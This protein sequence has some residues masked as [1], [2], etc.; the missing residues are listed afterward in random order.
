MSFQFFRRRKSPAL[1]PIEIGRKLLRALDDAVDNDTEGRLLGPDKFTIMLSEFDREA[2]ANDERAL[3]DELS[4]AATA[5]IRDEGLNVL[6]AIDVI[7]STDASLD[8]GQISAHPRDLG[9]IGQQLGAR[10]IVRRCAAGIG[11]DALFRGARWLLGVGK[12]E[13]TRP[14][15]SVAMVPSPRRRCE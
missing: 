3:I 5:Y 14:D 8:S 6:A 15:E 13:S 9:A 1:S 12:V 7:F 2:L 4:A 11:C 10:R